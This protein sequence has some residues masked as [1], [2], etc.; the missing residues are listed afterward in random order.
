M[1][2]I[3]WLEEFDQYAARD[4]IYNKTHQQIGICIWFSTGL[5]VEVYPLAGGGEIVRV[6]LS[7]YILPDDQKEFRSD[8]RSRLGIVQGPSVEND[9]SLCS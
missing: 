6:S 2:T 3:K 4:A 7:Q 1:N 8:V 9:L 5:A